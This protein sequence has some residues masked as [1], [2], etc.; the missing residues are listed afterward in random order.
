MSVIK[1]VSLA[2]VVLLI[3]GLTMGSICQGPRGS[4]GLQGPTGEQGPPGQCPAPPASEVL[5]NNQVVRIGAGEEKYLD[6]NLREGDRLSVLLTA[7]SI[8]DYMSCSMATHKP[9]KIPG[10]EC[11]S[12][13]GSVTD[14][15]SVYSLTFADPVRFDV[16]VPADDSYAIGLKN[17]SEDNQTVTVYAKR[18]PSILIWSG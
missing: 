17:P 7:G 1:R 14:N 13:N 15:G 18:Y 12:D 2:M 11:I 16:I 10:W 6:M 3:S 5:F 9:R 8:S 4:D